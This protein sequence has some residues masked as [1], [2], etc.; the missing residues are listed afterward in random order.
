MG[1]S[2]IADEEVVTGKEDFAQHITFVTKILQVLLCAEV[3]KTEGPWLVALGPVATVSLDDFVA[4][5]DEF[6]ADLATRLHNMSLRWRSE[7]THQM[8]QRC[9][10]TAYRSGEQD[11]FVEV[12]V[13]FLR[14]GAISEKVTDQGQDDCLIVGTEGEPV[15]EELL[16]FLVK[17]L[18]YLVIVK[19]GRGSFWS[20]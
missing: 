19:G 5:F 17:P 2:A 1:Q 10:A 4:V 6:K 20:Y 9:L 12:D 13:K 8:H 18:P 16:S 15:S 14:S 3:V 7:V 11:A